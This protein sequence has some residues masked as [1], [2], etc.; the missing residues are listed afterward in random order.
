[1]ARTLRKYTE[2]GKRIATLGK[3]TEI[4]K[5]L[6]MSQQTVSKKL[7]GEVVITVPDLQRLARKFKVPVCFFV[8][9]EGDCN[10]L[11]SKARTA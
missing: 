11:R 1:M 2:V 5:A 10:D 9:P 6:G 8:M 3:Q 7:R 4:A